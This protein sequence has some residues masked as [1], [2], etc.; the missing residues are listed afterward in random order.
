MRAALRV[1]A[2]SG[3]DSTPADNADKRKGVLPGLAS[4]PPKPFTS[5]GAALTCAALSCLPSQRSLLV[6]LPASLPTALDTLKT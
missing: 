2:A 5:H 3:Y 4:W 6:S 1:R